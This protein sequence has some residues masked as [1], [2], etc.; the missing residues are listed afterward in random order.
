MRVSISPLGRL[1]TVYEA[2]Q[3]LTQSGPLFDRLFIDT[4]GVSS[5]LAIQD[6]DSH[7]VNQHGQAPLAL[8]DIKRIFRSGP[9]RNSVRL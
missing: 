3:T 9:L 8:L 6:H 1:T 4:L 2:V 5:S 7:I